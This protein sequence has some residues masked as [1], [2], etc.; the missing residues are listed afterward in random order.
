VNYLSKFKTEGFLSSI[1]IFNSVEST[2]LQHD[3]TDTIKNYDIF[4]NE[5]RCKSHMLFKWID[6]LVHHPKIV[7]VVKELL[8]ENVI[9]HDTMFWGKMPGTDQFVSFHQDG[10]YWNIKEP[11]NG[12]TVWVP[13]QYS[14]EENGTIFYLKKSNK[15][16]IKHCDIE[17]KSNMLRRGQSIN[18]SDLPFEK[19]S[20]PTA[21]GEVT[22]HDPYCIH[23]S[24]P[25][26]GLDA[27]LACNIQ[28]VSA[29]SQTLINN[30]PEYGT[31][32]SGTNKSNILTVGRPSGI[33]EEDY[34]IWY[35]AWYNQR[36]NYLNHTGRN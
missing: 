12:V 19:V 30:Y 2:K 35:N 22:F 32:I 21:L 31:L 5:Y 17:N 4:N 33:F 1:D 27:R 20:C 14:N 8:G 25:N 24:Y 13:F 10:Y 29:S 9:C 28:Y 6:E 3:I 11:I 18:I 34:K 26:K 16:F 15:K 7:S 36:Q 23:G